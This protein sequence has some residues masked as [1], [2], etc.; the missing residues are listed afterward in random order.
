MVKAASEHL[1][2]SENN[3]SPRVASRPHELK[4][5]R[6]YENISRSMEVRTDKSERGSEQSEKRSEALNR[7]SSGS[8]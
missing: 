4:S 5:G 1:S 3:S 2:F 8:R 6:R 7:K